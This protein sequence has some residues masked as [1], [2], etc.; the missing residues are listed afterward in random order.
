MISD[1]NRIVFR[2]TGF[3][4]Q[5]SVMVVG[6]DREVSRFASYSLEVEA[7]RPGIFNKPANRFKDLLL[8][9]FVA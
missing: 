2:W 8:A 9:G 4:E 6:A 3:S 1:R 7:R 5:Y